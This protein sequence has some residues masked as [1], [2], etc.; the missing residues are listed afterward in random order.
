M[1][2]VVDDSPA[3]RDVYELALSMAGYP[4]E[5]A[6]DGRMALDIIEREVPEVMIL[7][8]MMP[9]MDGFELIEIIK[10]RQL[11][12]IAVIILTA[13]TSESTRI[14][15]ETVKTESFVKYVFYKPIPL[16]VILEKVKGLV[17]STLQGHA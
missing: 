16:N 5:I 13:S 10:K 6:Y 14:R 7:D 3:L 11:T 2:L 4:V 17:A 12:T 1:I 15:L 8:L 9:V